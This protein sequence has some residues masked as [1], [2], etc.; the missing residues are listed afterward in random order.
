MLAN[1]LGFCGVLI[2]TPVGL[3][4]LSRTGMESALPIVSQHGTA[5]AIVVVVL[6]AV[7]MV[8]VL[9]ALTSATRSH[10]RLAKLLL[11]SSHT[12]DESG[13][14]M[15][16]L[17]HMSS[18]VAYSALSWI[19]GALALYVVLCGLATGSAI[20]LGDV[21]GAAALAAALGSLAV[22]APEGVGVKDGVLVALLTHATGLSLADCVA[23]AVAVRALDPLTKLVLLF[24]V[25]LSFGAA[26]TRLSARLGAWPRP[27]RAATLH[28]Y[29]R[30]ESVPGSR[31]GSVPHILPHVPVLE[32]LPH[33]S[34]QGL[35][36]DLL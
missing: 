27:S 12:T 3:I 7:G 20:N 34:Q 25:A 14:G 24:L 16:R 22:F 2:W 19:V 21:V 5:T 23:A 31:R 8:V 32:V 15:V 6:M 36:G 28:V 1:A 29:S 35:P 13:A 11:G 18:L 10:T 17:K 26:W 33:H 30:L 9:Q 4:L